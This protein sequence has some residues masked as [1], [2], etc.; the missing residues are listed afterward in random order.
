MRYISE[1]SCK[2]CPLVLISEEHSY[3]DLP[4]LSVAISQSWISFLSDS[5]MKISTVSL[6]ELPVPPTT[7]YR[8]C[9]SA[10]GK[11]KKSGRSIN[12][13]HEGRLILPAVSLGFPGSDGAAL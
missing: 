8:G 2:L 11:S 3:L 10:S 7:Q 6:C 12:L 13:Y 9:D 1:P 4:L 5:E